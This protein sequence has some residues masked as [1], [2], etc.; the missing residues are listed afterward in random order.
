[1]SIL[2][3]DLM[4]L[5]EDSAMLFQFLQLC[6][7]PPSSIFYTLEVPVSNPPYFRAHSHH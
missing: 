4:E 6:M 2:I 3:L 7:L 5:E 1:M